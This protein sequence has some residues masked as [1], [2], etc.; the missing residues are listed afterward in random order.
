MAESKNL[1]D[2]ISRIS[3]LSSAGVRARGLKGQLTYDLAKQVGDRARQQAARDEQVKLRDQADRDM[4]ALVV[5]QKQ[6]EDSKAKLQQKID[7]T[8]YELFA[9][10]NQSTALAQQIAQLLQDQQDAIIA[11]AMQ[12]VWDQVRIYEQ[13]N[14]VV[15]IGT[16]SNHSKKYRFM[17]PMPG[18]TISQVYGPTQLGFEPAYAGFAH[19]HTGLD[20]C[21]PE[22][23]PVLAADDGIVIL[24]GSGPY[25]YGNYLVVQHQGGL[26]TL[27]GHLNRAVVHVGDQVTQGQRIGLEGTTGNSTGPHL[28]FELRIDNKP[29]DPALYLPPGPPNDFRG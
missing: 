13:Q 23:A 15:G 14:P 25:G 29:V 28:H 11:A 12:Q 24:V 20:M 3:D 2:M 22:G 6:Q 4:A 19:F 10:Q 16:S 17:W 8:R 7:Q 27:Y 26:T 9:V 1:A 5:L 18:S 21:L